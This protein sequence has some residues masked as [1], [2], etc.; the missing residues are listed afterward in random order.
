M[1]VRIET[2][3]KAAGTAAP[4]A[5]V[6]LGPILPG[7][8]G[9]RRSRAGA[10]RVRRV[11][12]LS[13]AQPPTLTEWTNIALVDALSADIEAARQ[14]VCTE[15]R[16]LSHTGDHIEILRHTAQAFVV[17]GF[18]YA[19]VASSLHIHRNTALQR[20]KKAEALRGRPLTERPAELLAALAIVDTIGPALDEP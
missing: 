16:A 4:N 3:T 15:L 8:N 18:S 1:R 2:L 20:V 19:A 7:L 14:L 13:A 5:H 10:E 6:A 17:S 9:F 11:V 12:S